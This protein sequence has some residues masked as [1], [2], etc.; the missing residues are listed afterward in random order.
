MTT[1]LLIASGLLGLLIGSFLNVV[2]YRVPAGK[3]IVSPPS[4]CP[5]C[6][7]PVRAY[8]NIPVVSWLVLR[9]KCRDCGAPISLRYI[10]VE[11]TTGILFVLVAWRFAAG[12]E[13]ASTSNLLVARLIVLIAFLYLAAISVALVLIDV[14]THR[15]PNVLTLPSYV[16]GVALLLAASALGGE[17]G[18][19]LRAVASMAILV[20]AYL[21]MAIVYRGG[22]GL[23]DVKLAGVI[24]LFLGWIGWG[25]LL[26][27][28]FS[29]FLL[30]GIFGVILL[31][32]RR[33]NRRSGIP[34]GPWMVIGAAVGV[35]FGESLWS[36]Y[37][38]LVG[39]A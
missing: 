13:L 33:A 10:L 38:D 12:I 37:L 34:F 35:G 22:M 30:G 18:A 16:V 9:A 31:L 11:L 17:W 14:D 19:L 23:G 8:D 3:S 32:S 6:G 20:A 26:V 21:I 25:S 29:A 36:G 7:A 27:G 4:A 28:A 1:A 39:L 24:G 15:L 2:V 5:H